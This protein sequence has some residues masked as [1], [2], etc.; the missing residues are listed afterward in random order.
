MYNYIELMYKCEYNIKCL[1]EDNC[2]PI[3]LLCFNELYFNYAKCG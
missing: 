2:N 1:T 3:R